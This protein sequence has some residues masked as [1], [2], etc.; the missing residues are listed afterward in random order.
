VRILQVTH[1]FP[2]HYIGGVELITQAL[3]QG[4]AQHGHTV[5]V[6]TRAPVAK[7]TQTNE[8]G[9]QVHRLPA[10]PSQTA[11]FAAT[12]A[13]SA[14]HQ[15]LRNL[16]RAIQPDLVHIQ[17]LMGYPAAWLAGLA[18]L[19]TPYL[20]SLHDYWF[21]C[22]NAQLITNY[23]QSLC[24]GPAGANCG[25]C[26]AA[27]ASLRLP[28][29]LNAVAGAALTPL[30]QARNNLLR[31][32]LQHAAK[33]LAPSQFVRNW[34]VSAGWVDEAACRVI[35]SGIDPPPE[36]FARTAPPT[37]QTRFAFVGGL[38]W[39]KG[40]HV[41]VQ[42]FN[43]LPADVHATLSI[44]GDLDAFPSYVAELR[45]SAKHANVHWLGKLA[46]AQ[47]WELLRRTDVVVVPSLWHE[48]SSLIAREALA[49]GCTLI[50]S[51]VG[52]LDEV[53]ARAA[54]GQAFGVAPG[55]V[56]Q[57][58]QAL[59]QALAHP[60]THTHPATPARV[61]ADYVADIEALYLSI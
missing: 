22:A 18:E 48:T 31:P 32:L 39:Q 55:D 60:H 49:A 9:V 54:P 42:A 6:V 56:A 10:A 7:T 16:M 19:N 33:V 13:D 4:L 34:F 28:N 52:A 17:H 44:A 12:F 11:R 25:R 41:L 23:S 26:A 2:P 37:G 59:Q 53:L 40:V 3:A 30:M 46:P 15:H 45:H 20:V 43:E 61:M 24:A 8:A 38:A 50:A 36:N 21:A 29:A 27:R 51:R 35:E 58:A 1:Q 14:T 47:R 5:H 57:L